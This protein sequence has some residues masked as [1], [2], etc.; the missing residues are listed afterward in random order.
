MERNLIILIFLLSCVSLDYAK[1]PQ[2]GYRGFTDLD[3]TTG[4]ASF[5]GHNDALD[6]NYYIGVSTSHGY[7]F[8]NHVFLGGGVNISFGHPGCLIPVFVDFRYDTSLRKLNPFGDIRVG[9]NIEANGGLYVSPTVGHRFNISKKTNFN[10]GIG[11]TFRGHVHDKY[12]VESTYIGGD[13]NNLSINMTSDGKTQHIY[14]LFT[15]R[16][17]FDF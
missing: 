11:M 13:P 1:E 5:S 17:G 9:Y 15:I 12:K 2:R 8:N 14:S 6:W 7:Q 10:L 3:V 16:L 4:P